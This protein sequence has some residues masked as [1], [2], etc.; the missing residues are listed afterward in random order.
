MGQKWHPRK[1]E[2]ALT[3]NPSFDLWESCR[4][5]DVF[6]A[7][8]ILRSIELNG[9]NMS[10]VINSTDNDG[11][12]PLIM[13]LEG[14]HAD[15]VQILLTQNCIDVN[16]GESNSPL[17]VACSNGASQIAQLLISHQTTN[18]NTENSGGYTALYYAIVYGHLSI[19]EMLLAHPNINV[20]KQDRFGESCLHFVCSS[21]NV[22]MTNILLGHINTD[23]NLG[24][25]DTNETALMLACK[26]DHICIVQQLLSHPR[27]EVRL[28]DRDGRFA[29][30]YVNEGSQNCAAILDLLRTHSSYYFKPRQA[31]PEVTEYSNVDP[32]RDPCRCM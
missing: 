19:A 24:T 2:A 30:N 16:K 3:G 4:Q 9:S 20:N 15:I 29:E 1:K 14:N 11:R 22:E 23:V 18:V 27:I 13:A 8:S 28:L 31:S 26:F 12:T 17:H 25:L 7:Q 10:E 32:N 6:A 5:G 21:G